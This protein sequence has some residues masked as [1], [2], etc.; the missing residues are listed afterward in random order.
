MTQY[1]PN[2]RRQFNP[3]ESVGAG[4][5][6]LGGLWTGWFHGG[7]KIS[8]ETSGPFPAAHFNNHQLI[9]IPGASSQWENR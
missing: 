8:Q 4:I 7:T 1:D 3:L 9:R 6:S 5:S 2:E